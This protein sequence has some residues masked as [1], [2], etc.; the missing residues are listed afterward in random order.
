MYAI[1]SYYEL[2]TP[3]DQYNEEYNEMLNNIP[4]HIRSLVLFV[5]RL[6]RNERE[7]GNWK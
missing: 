5:K 6:Y 2:L 1:R 7:A 3:S 4:D